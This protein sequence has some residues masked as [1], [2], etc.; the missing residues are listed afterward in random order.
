MKEASRVNTY[1]VRKATQPLLQIPEA[2]Q[3]RVYYNQAPK[4]KNYPYAVYY[5][6]PD[7]MQHP[8]EHWMLHIEIY[9]KSDNANRIEEIADQLINELDF[10]NTPNETILPTFYFDD[11]DFSRDTDK[12]LLII[13]LRFEI[14]NYENE[15]GE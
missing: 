2:L 12:G 11:R 15:S 5:L 8:A 13:D 7:S 9:D 14:N 10:A 1:A 4:D 3:K 6:K